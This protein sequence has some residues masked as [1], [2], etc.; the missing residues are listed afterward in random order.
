MYIL[1]LTYA[2]HGDTLARLDSSVGS[3][4]LIVLK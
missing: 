1:I 4:L 2:T 3:V